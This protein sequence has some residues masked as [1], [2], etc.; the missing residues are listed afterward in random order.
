MPNWR[1]LKNTNVPNSSDERIDA[2]HRQTFSPYA[3]AAFDR[4]R[5]LGGRFV[6][7]TTAATAVQILGNREIWMRNTSAMNDFAVLHLAAKGSMLT[8]TRHPER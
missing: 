2:L 1:R 5:T 3:A 7:Y 6:Y 4:A 8:S